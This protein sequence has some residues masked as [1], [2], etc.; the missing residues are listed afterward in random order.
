MPDYTLKVVSNTILK[1]QPI[2]SSRITEPTDKQAVEAG[3]AF[4][5]HSY[6]YDEGSQ[7][8]KISFL[9]D[10]FQGKNVWW[11]YEEHVEILQN[12]NILI[13]GMPKAVNL[14]VP[15]FSQLDN[16]YTPYGSCNV[17]SVAMCLYY[18]GLRSQDPGEQLEDELYQYCE[19]QGLDRHLG[20]HLAQIIADYG[21]QD[22][23]QEQAR[24]DDVKNWLDKGNPAIVH[25]YFTASGHII[26][27][28]GYND[29]GW[30][31]N[32]PYGEWFEDGYDTN[33][34]GEGLTYSYGMMERVCGSDGD[35]WMHFVS[36]T[37]V[38]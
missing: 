20:A 9:T 21:Y 2:P 19:T 29:R 1:Q 18:F 31:V 16:I 7:H 28:R 35:L 6:L 25:G 32:D 23:Y 5:L 3:K 24:W 8:Y 30:V 13:K 11:A 37:S 34:S 26:V 12:G 14:N 33:A 36:K 38:V 17:T 4:A 22:D 10:S 27:I 15:W